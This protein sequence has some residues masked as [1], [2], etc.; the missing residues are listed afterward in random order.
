MLPAAS[1]MI[2]IA[3]T[4]SSTK[5]GEDRPLASVPSLT[6]SVIAAEAACTAAALSACGRRCLQEGLTRRPTELEIESRC[7]DSRAI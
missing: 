4:A 6:P 2:A 7:G 3:A 5:S 1:A